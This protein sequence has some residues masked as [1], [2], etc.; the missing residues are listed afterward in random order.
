MSPP[1]LGLKA[2][3]G[4]SGSPSAAAPND[5]DPF[6]DDDA[7]IIIKKSVGGKNATTVVAATAATVLRFETE[8]EEHTH[9]RVAPRVQVSLSFEEEWISKTNKK[10]GART[11]DLHT[12]CG[13]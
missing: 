9:S 8:E 13:V 1:L 3:E 7:I 2:K 6:D 12:E 11:H 5:D 10:R 4:R